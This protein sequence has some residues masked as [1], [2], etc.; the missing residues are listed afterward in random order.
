MSDLGTPSN[1]NPG[2]QYCSN[3]Q[4][5]LIPTR[6][7]FVLRIVVGNKGGGEKTRIQTT[8][9]RDAVDYSVNF[10]SF[11]APAFGAETSLAETRE[12]VS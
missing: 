6:V 5:S 4:R 12:A 8:T 11:G 3:C 7:G 1:E 9:P 2:C 10:G